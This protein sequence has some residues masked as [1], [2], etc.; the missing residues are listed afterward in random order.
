[1]LFELGYHYYHNYMVFLVEC[2][3]GDGI[4]LL[5]ISSS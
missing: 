1:M 3:V 5:L 2:S 4:F